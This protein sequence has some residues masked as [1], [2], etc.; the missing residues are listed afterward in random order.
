MVRTR[1]LSAL[2][3]SPVA[4]VTG[5]RALCGRAPDLPAAVR[6]QL[7]AAYPGWGFARLAPRLRSELVSE[8]GRRRSPEW[9]PGDF[10]GDRRTDYAVQIVRPGA[11]DSAQ[12]VL[13]FVA[14]P[15]GYRR[16]VLQ[17]TGEHLGLYLRT[18]RR[19]ER[20]LDLDRN[21]NGDSSFVLVH[22]AVDI[23]S[24]EGT[25]TTCLYELGRWR[26]ITSGD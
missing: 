18:S 20:V 7:T 25:G 4:F 9:V 12:L 10:N 8:P 16:F 21:A 5:P 23:L 22:D 26:C 6:A 24:G 11:A 1:L 3:A 17:S 19:G 13:A 2:L 14:S 15:G